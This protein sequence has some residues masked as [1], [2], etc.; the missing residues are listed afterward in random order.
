MVGVCVKNQG[1]HA[2]WCFSRNPEDEGVFFLFCREYHKKKNP[3]VKK[4]KPFF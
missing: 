4:V 2:L 1:D 3:S